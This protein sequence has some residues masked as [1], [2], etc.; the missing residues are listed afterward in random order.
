MR[1]DNWSFPSNLL[2]DLSQLGQV[3]RGTPWQTLYLKS[4][5]ADALT[6]QMWAGATNVA[7]AAAL[8][9]TNDWRIASLLLNLFRTN[10]PIDL[11]SSNPP[12][13]SGWASSLDGITVF[14]NGVPPAAQFPMTSNSPQAAAIAQALAFAQT[15]RPWFRDPSEIVS[16]P[17]L[18]TTSPWLDTT[19]PS[20]S[21]LAYEAIP[22]QLLLR[23]RKDS[24]ARILGSSPAHIE[25]TG[26]DFYNYAIE[27]SADLAEW[28]VVSTSSPTNG[29]LDFTDIT[30]P[31]TGQIYY[32]T[33][34]LP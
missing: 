17:E 10:S 15:S 4:E 25:F 8:H 12:D 27:R 21:D 22:S 26:V 28:T 3:H 18:S 9:P 5:S 33:R 34:L 11:R 14:T 31:N 13:L 20:I 30:A 23:L 6:W 7:D 1:S 29:I 32:R 16:I 2:T 24:V 19:G